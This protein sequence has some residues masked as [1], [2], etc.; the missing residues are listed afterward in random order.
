MKGF[1]QNHLS[2]LSQFS[3]IKA[4]RID[5]HKK[6]PL[7]ELLFLCVN[8]VACGYTVWE[9]ITDFGEE[10]LL[11]LRTYLPY[12][13]GICSHDTLNRVMGLLDYQAFEVFVVSW[14]QSLV[15]SLGANWST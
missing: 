13:N 5:R 6:Y 12:E 14:V 15:E 7:N 3:W 8:G 9:E 10:K 2:L 11:W 4:P 1:E